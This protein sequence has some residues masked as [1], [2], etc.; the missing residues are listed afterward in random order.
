[1]MDKESFEKSLKNPL[2]FWGKKSLSDVRILLGDETVQ[3]VGFDQ[4]NPH[5]CYDL[6]MHTLHTVNNLDYVSSTTLRVAAFFHDIG[7]PYV[8]QEKHGRLV[9]YGHAKKSAKVAKLILKN[10]GYT[11]AEENIICFYISHHDDFIS[12]VL[13]TEPYDRENPYLVEITSDNVAT[14][15]RKVM[16]D[17]IAPMVKNNYELWTN[18]LHLCRADAVSQS[19]FV[20]SDGIVIDSKTHKLKKIEAVE[21]ALKNIFVSAK[22]H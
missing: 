17:N 4:H 21:T 10:L 11:Q 18:L 19:E 14:H 2:R 15:I 1:M 13:P 3:M 16:E 5:Y 20:Y 12:W 7:K 22:N 9:F 6:F 8:A